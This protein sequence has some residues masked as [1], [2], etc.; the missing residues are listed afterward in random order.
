MKHV[1][2]PLALFAAHATVPEPEA[3]DGSRGCADG[4]LYLI[5]IRG[6]SEMPG[7]GVAGTVIG[8]PVQKQINGTKVVA[9]DY[10]ATYSDPNYADSVANGTKSLSKLMSAHVKSCPNDKIAIV[11]YSQGAQV[12]LDTICGSDE[13]SFDK[14]AAIAPDEVENHVVAIALMGDPTHVANVAYNRGTSTGNGIFP[15]QDTD[16]CLRYANLISSWCDTGDIYCDSGKSA[17]VHGQYFEKYG[18]DIIKFIV[19][20]ARRSTGDN[21]S[22]S[23][24]HGTGDSTSSVSPSG[25]AAPTGPGQPS[26]ST[27]SSASAPAP[28]TTTTTTTSA[29]AHG[30]TKASKGLVYVALPLVLAAMF[31][32]L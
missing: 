17:A 6:T 27:T 4:G 16:S 19:D 31:Q 7:I 22:H 25:T 15:R 8:T 20:K 5:T 29:A 13:A 1:L 14:T 11:A 12:A 9:L 24:S 10:P 30:V 23:T 26:A 3:G 32:M 28:A 18:T 21:T 2:A